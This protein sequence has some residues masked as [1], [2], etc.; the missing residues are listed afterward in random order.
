WKVCN[1]ILVTSENLGFVLRQLDG[2]QIQQYQDYAME[3][4]RNVIKE[5]VV[6]RLESIISNS[7]KKIFLVTIDRTIRSAF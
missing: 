3:L 1:I 4:C 2:E 6:F 5:I 7:H